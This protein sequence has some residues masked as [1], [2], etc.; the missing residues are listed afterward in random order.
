MTPCDFFLFDRVKKS[1]DNEIDEKDKVDEKNE[2]DKV[3]DLDK[4]KLEGIGY[5][6]KADP[7]T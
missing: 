1:L 4:K 7:K 2:K 6:T 3:K 5:R